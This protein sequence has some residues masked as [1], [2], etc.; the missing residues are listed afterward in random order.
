MK[1]LLQFLLF[2][3]VLIIWLA[4]CTPTPTSTE[5]PVA[6]EAPDEAGFLS[7]LERH[8]DAVSQK[9]LTTLAVTMSEAEG[10]YLILPDREPTI[11][12]EAFL[13]MH[14]EWFAAG[15]WTFETKILH[16][17]L[18]HDLG[19]AIVDVLYKEPERNGKPYYNH[20]IV[21]YD[22]KRVGPN[23]F[24]IKD[25]ACSIDKTN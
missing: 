25:Q 20:M 18:S 3:L 19:L 21:S 9:D 10:M 15:P 11:T 8:L 5:G 22:L 1:K 24:V 17:E 2:G 7:T 13:E 4:A 16:T 12:V 6:V 14:K 23:W